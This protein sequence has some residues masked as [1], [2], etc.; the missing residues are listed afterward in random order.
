MATTIKDENGNL[1]W[2]ADDFGLYS[3]MKTDAITEILSELLQNITISV[4][5]HSGDQ[6]ITNVY[7]K[8]ESDARFIQIAVFP[9]MLE[10]QISQ[11]ISEGRIVGSDTIVLINTRLL[12]LYR[13]CFGEDLDGHVVDIGFDD[14]ISSL[15]LSVSAINT[16]VH[17]ILRDIYQVKPDGSIDTTKLVVAK[18][19]DT[20]DRSDLDPSISDI[21][22]MVA[23]INSV[24]SGVSSVASS[25]SGLN[26]RVGSLETQSGSDTLN[27]DADTLSGAINEI[28]SELG[29]VSD[30]DSG[31][32]TKEVVSA[33]NQLIGSMNTLSGQISNLEQRV[34]A[35]ENP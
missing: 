10:G 21:S 16:N 25:V 12:R 7:T 18:L 2:Q 11:L 24:N 9:M 14:K 17:T 33:L 22:T 3:V 5:T 30:L 19:S 31:F 29:K 1:L 23:A 26:S 34:S 28:D 27:T 6:P 4:E 35:L 8:E 13:S 32:T 20:G 15:D